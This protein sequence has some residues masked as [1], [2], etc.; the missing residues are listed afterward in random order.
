MFKKSIIRHGA[1]DENY[2]TH[3]LFVI[4]GLSDF[5][6]G[7]VKKFRFYLLI[8]RQV[9]RTKYLQN[10]RR[11]QTVALGRK[12]P[13]VNGGLPWSSAAMGRKR[14]FN[15]SESSWSAANL[16]MRNM[17]STDRQLPIIWYK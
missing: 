5:L 1:T 7:D 6:G 17:K 13:V 8:R 10:N 14:P 15:G 12:Q 3:I 11:M 4:R 2:N 9:K 16:M